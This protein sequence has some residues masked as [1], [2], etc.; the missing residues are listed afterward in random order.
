LIHENESVIRK[1]NKGIHA[2]NY[3]PYIGAFSVF[4]LE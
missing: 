3:R 4:P 2:H 1:P